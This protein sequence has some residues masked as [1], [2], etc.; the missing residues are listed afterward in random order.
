MTHS[1]LQPASYVRRMTTAR[2]G[3]LG[4]G[5]WSVKTLPAPTVLC[6]RHAAAVGLGDVLDDGQAEPRAA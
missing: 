2:N 3:Q 4:A 6:D 1:R 5:R